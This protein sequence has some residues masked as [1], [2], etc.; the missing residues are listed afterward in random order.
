MIAADGWV[1]LASFVFGSLCLGSAGLAWGL[2]LGE[3]GRRQAAET[4][5]VL[6][7]PE[8][9]PASRV[10]MKNAPLLEPKMAPK[11]WDKETLDKGAAAIKE[12]AQAAGMP[13]SDDQALVMAAD[14]LHMAMV[15][16]SEDDVSVG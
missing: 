16:G 1:G 14:M 12:Q 5:L 6:G 2:Y 4:L 13:V 8:A 15:G 3:R 9:K 11:G 10:T 7:T